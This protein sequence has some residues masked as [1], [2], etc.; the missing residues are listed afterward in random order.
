MI[1]QE[2]HDEVSGKNSRSPHFYL[3]V[4]N[5]IIMVNFTFTPFPRFKI[6]ERVIRDNQIS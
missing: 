6:L 2:H 4:N 5:M 1:K 3:I